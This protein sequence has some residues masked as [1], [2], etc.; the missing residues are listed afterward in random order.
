MNTTA[1]AQ[2]LNVLDSAIIE[3]QEWASVV[4][5]K[6]IGGCRFVSKKVMGTKTDIEKIE[7]IGGNRW[8]KDDYD[9]IYFQASLIAK[10]LKLSNSKSRQIASN[11]FY[12]DVKTKQFQC[13]VSGSG[14][15]GVT[16]APMSGN[17][18]KNAPYWVDA[19]K[20]L[21]GV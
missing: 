18:T 7:D 17:G 11:K 19:I 15:Y 5:V 8:Q 21:A 16:D 2:H 9:R 4:W 14:T 1:I 12:Y 3:V 6:F 13:A 10:T 20:Q